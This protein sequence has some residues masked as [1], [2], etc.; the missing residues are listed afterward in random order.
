[1]GSKPHYGSNL[2]THETGRTISSKLLFDQLRELIIQH[3]GD[4]Y[5]LRITANN[6]LILTK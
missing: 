1:M 4:E 3:E 2:A 6:K 5:K